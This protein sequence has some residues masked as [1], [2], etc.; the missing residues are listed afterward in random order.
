VSLRPQTELRAV[1]VPREHGGWGL[2]LEPG[3]LG[4]LLAPSVAGGCL[5]AAAMVA[6]VARTPLKVVAVDLYRRRWID[7]TR[8]AAAIG[9]VELLVLAGLVG[10]A[11]GL[12]AK[13]FWVPAVLAAPLIMV[14]AWFEVR[15]RGRQ[16]LPEL[17]GAAGVCAVAGIVVLAGGGAGRL[18]AGASLLLTARVATSI[19]HVRAQIAR[20]HGRP[21]QAGILAAADAAAMTTAAGAVWLE[22][23]LLMA[24]GTVG[25][26]VG[27]Q[28]AAA[29]R[30]VPRAAILGIRQ[31]VMGVVVV[32]VAAVGVHSAWSWG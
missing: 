16:L 9:A 4:L 8:L 30:P 32:I 12:S 21:T 2:T 22:P 20:L 28:R 13:S 11:V 24:A 3:L 1:A 7:R 10:A 6:F 14:E 29:R 18:A 19:P 31:M 15:S 17:A 25:A 5:A 27:L 23:R 26:V